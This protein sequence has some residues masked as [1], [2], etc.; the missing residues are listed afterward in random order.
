MSLGERGYEPAQD[1]V[2]DCKK[3]RDCL[4]LAVSVFDRSHSHSG[5]SFQ[6]S[7]CSRLLKS[8]IL[9][10]ILFPIRSEVCFETE[11][12]LYSTRSNGGAMRDRTADLLRAR[13]AL[14]QLSYNPIQS[15]VYLL[16]PTRLAAER[17]NVSS[18][19]CKRT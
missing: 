12:L 1:N 2:Q 10:S 19:M 6:I 4:M 8:K 14:S 13:Q 5:L 15:T 18:A 7:A 17:F 11:P 9:R 16:I 3:L